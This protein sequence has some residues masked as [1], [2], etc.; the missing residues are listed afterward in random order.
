MVIIGI[1]SAVQRGIFAVAL[2]AVIATGSRLA[3]AQ[4]STRASVNVGI[5]GISSSI[6]PAIVAE[7]KGFF[8]EQGLDVSLISTG[9]SARVLQ[10]VAAG[11]VEIGSSSFV[12]AVRAIEGGGNIRIFLNSQAVGT[13]TLVVASD[14]KSVT[15]LKG[16]RVITG[17]Q[18][19]LT[20]IWWDALARHYGLDPSRD[21]ELI[22]AGA[23][24]ARMAA[25]MAG[26][27]QGAILSPPQNFRAVQEGWTDLGSA[28]PFLG[29]FPTQ[30]WDVNAGWA[31]SHE[32]LVVSFVKAHN[33]AVRYMM[34][35]AHRLEA[36]EI[37]AKTANT[38]LD[39]ALKTWD[40]NAQVKAYSYDGSI[41]Q[42]AVKRIVETLLSIG[43]VQPPAKSPSAY[44]D[45]R[46]VEAA[47]Q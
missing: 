42:Q 6:W 29:D 23:S 44:Y 46:Y 22:F 9:A 14:I 24:S 28:A 34:D 8:E 36:S 3:N 20:N 30:I 15:D 5:I 43:D 33:R 16:R 39:D 1:V 4:T 17:G 26:G 35:P 37:L 19:D 45:S 40:Q 12:D 10:Q 13:Y 27:V 32:K 25:L 21:V 38:P 47:A 7:K 11:A 2:F 41:S 31:A 18:K